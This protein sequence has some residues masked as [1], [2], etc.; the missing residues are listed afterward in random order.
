MTP[1]LVFKWQN[2][3][4]LPNL[5]ILDKDALLSFI[6]IFFQAVNFYLIEAAL[7]IYMMFIIC[8][9]FCTLLTFALLL[10]L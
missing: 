10:L 3:S 6:W 9:F 5:V 2:S 4:V 8:L 7:G 1:N